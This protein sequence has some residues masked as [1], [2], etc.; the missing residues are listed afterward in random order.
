MPID[1]SQAFAAARPVAQHCA[2]L[3]TRGPRPE[4]RAEALAAWRRDLASVLARDLAQLLSGDRPK[5]SIGEPETLTGKEAFERI[6]PVAAYSL[7]RCGE[8]QTTVLLSFDFATA[9]ALTDRSFGGEGKPVEDIPEQL[10]RSATLLVEQFAVLTARAIGAAGDGEAGDATNASVSGDVIARSDSAARLKPFGPDTECAVL[11][12]QIS[13]GADLSWSALLALP[14]DRLDILLP[15]T[16]RT[17]GQR[18]TLSPETAATKRPFARI[19]LTLEAVL[20]EIDLSLGR[21]G[22]LK[23]GD[24]IPLAMPRTVPLKVGEEV[25]A[26]GTL[27]TFED[28]MALRLTANPSPGVSS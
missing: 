20:A 17:C 22:A 13:A 24:E 27:G 25:F 14:A 10:P 15:G 4:E 7:L 5:V 6:G 1:N 28:R 9:I 2:E 23:P 3:V 19:P 12:V 16:D 8:S 18:Q 21:L 11:T 26:H